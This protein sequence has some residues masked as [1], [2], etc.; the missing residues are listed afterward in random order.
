MFYHFP[1]FQYTIYCST[2]T[3]PKFQVLKWLIMRNSPKY[4]FVIAIN[5]VCLLMEML[6]QIPDRIQ[7]L[8]EVCGKLISSLKQ[9]SPTALSHTYGPLR[10]DVSNR[11]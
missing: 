10:T 6:C 4:K 1:Y 3:L 11:F 8:Y 2:A 9:G 7:N 5:N